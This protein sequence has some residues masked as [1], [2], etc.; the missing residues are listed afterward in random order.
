LGA[1]SAGSFSRLLE[2]L[3]LRMLG[4]LAWSSAAEL[5]A[6]PAAAVAAAAADLGLNANSLPSKP[7]VAPPTLPTPPPPP[8]PLLLLPLPLPPPPSPLPAAVLLLC[9]G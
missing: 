6:V 4:P 7:L 2:L 5:C 1:K 8:P 9:A 3:A